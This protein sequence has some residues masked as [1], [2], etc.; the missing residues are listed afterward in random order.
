MRGMDVASFLAI[1][2]PLYLQA[3]AALSQP[4]RLAREALCSVPTQRVTLQSLRGGAEFEAAIGSASGS[5]P[6]KPSDFVRRTARSTQGSA[7]GEQR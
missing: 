6:T 3:D 2:R 7:R 5:T 4:L 1:A